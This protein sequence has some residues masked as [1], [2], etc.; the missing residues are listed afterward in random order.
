MLGQLIHKPDVFGG[1]RQ[2][3][4]SSLRAAWT[5]GN[6]RMIFLRRYGPL[7]W[8]PTHNTHVVVSAAPHRRGDSWTPDDLW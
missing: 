2:L 7:P 4:P 3:P 6:V 8:H 1:I 5:T